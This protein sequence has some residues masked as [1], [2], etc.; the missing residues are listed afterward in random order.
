MFNLNTKEKKELLKT[1]VTAGI[2][3]FATAAA[4]N[5]G[6]ADGFN[7]GFDDGFDAQTESSNQCSDETSEEVVALFMIE[8]DVTIQYGSLTITRS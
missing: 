1:F 4:Y 6:N 3:G 2:V 7:E 5:K 8:N